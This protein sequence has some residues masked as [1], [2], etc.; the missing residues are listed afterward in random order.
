MFSVACPVGANPAQI[1]EYK[2][3][4][5]HKINVM[6]CI[7]TCKKKAISEFEVVPDGWIVVDELFAVKAEKWK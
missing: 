6:R 7:K 5:A 4:P 1:I 2:R 3:F